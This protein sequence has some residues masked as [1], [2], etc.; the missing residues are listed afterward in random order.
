MKR[1]I[2]PGGLVAVMLVALAI[3]TAPARASIFEPET[4]TLDNGMQVVLISNQ[5]APVVR[6][7]VWYRV[8]SAD[9]A[10]GESGIAHL[11]EHLMFKGTKTYAPGVFSGEIARNGGRENAFTS[12]DYT[13]YFQT[14]AKDRLDMV[15]RFEADRMTNL[16]I[17]EEQVAPERQVVLEERKSR[18]D[19]RPSSQLGE[20]VNAALYLNYPYRRPII[21]WEHE[22]RELN[23]ERILAFYRKFYAPNNAILIV[24]GDVTLEELK[25]LAEKYYGVIPR[26]PDI[27]RVR[28]TEPKANADRRVTL[29]HE[30]ATQARWGRTYLGPSYNYGGR[31]HVYALQVLSDVMDSIRNE[32]LHKRLVLD[33]K[34]A[35]RAGMYYA[36]DAYGPATLGFYATLRDGVTAADVEAVIDEEIARVLRDG[37]TEAEVTAAKEQMANR[38]IY[39]RDNFGTAARVFGVTLTSG[40]TVDDVETWLDQINAVTPAQVLAAARYML[41]GTH[42]VTSELRPKPQS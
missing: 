26:G 30:R 36:P 1:T 5:R 11:L 29:E 2:F 22:I 19:N 17:T 9:E 39:A 18:V 38:A 24:E 41:D 15:M 16:T 14:I 6:H 35:L 12:F 4:F 13:A 28:T 7:M 23:V 8:G 32:R 40:G 21:G 3:A 42:H 10:P 20:V 33:E 34:L 37:V 31:E 25:P 27:K